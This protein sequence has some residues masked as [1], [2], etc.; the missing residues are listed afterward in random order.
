MEEEGGERWNAKT[1]EGWVEGYMGRK[2]DE[3]SAHDSCKRRII[4]SV[5]RIARRK[6]QGRMMTARIIGRRM[7]IGEVGS[8]NFSKPGFGIRG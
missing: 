7:G 2:M 1:I 6:G 8:M 4:R 5:S 3:R